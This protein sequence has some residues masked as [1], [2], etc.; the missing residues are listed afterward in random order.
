MTAPTDD[1]LYD[2]LGTALSRLP[3]AQ[4]PEWADAAAAETAVRQL[5]ALPPL[6]FAGECDLLHDRLAAVSRGEAFLLQG[7]DCAETFG[8]VT[9]NNVRNKLKTLLQMAVVLT[10]AASVP[11]VKVGRIAGQYTKPRSRPTETRGELTLPAYRG[12]MVNGFDFTDDARSADPARMV[13]AYHAAAAT[14]NLTRA[15]IGGGYADL[16]EVHAWNTD[17]VRTSPAGQRYERLAGEIEKALSFMRAI[18][19]DPEQLHTVEFFASHEAL[20][21]DY[22]RALTRIDSRTGRPYAVSGHLLWVGERTRAPDG[23]HVEFAARIRNPVAVKLGPAASPEDVLALAER[24][25]PDREPG[26]LTLVSRMGASRVRDALPPLV[27]KATASGL[28][29]SWICDPMHGNTY[30][31]V[32]GHKTRRFDDVVDEIQG[33]FD[34]H[35]S[36]GTVPGGLH[37][38]LTGDDVTE[39]VGGGDPIREDSLADRYETF[40]DPRLNRTQS[41]ELAFLVAE[42]LESRRRIQLSPS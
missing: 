9:A 16:R 5:R 35:R 8:G 25:D 14:L 38:E 3:A 18:G 30:E 27:E 20:L 10:Y 22:E 42:L 1:A 17:F 13:R 24:I 37:V 4:Q 6:V 31:A 29:V 15:F 19:A 34:V 23:A 40:C 33:F 2:Q 32:S 11:V 7:G 28:T 12:D 26:R 36:L 21:L 41:L 39:C